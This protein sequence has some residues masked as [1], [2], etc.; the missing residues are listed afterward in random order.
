VIPTLLAY[1][2]AFRRNAGWRSFAL[3]T[4]IWAPAAVAAFVL[5][6]ALGEPNQGTSERIYLAVYVS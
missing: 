6:I 4:L 1:A 5:V 3:P 2:W